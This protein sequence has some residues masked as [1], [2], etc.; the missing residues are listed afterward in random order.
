MVGPILGPLDHE[1]ALDSARTTI[2]T[3]T[4][5]QELSKKL[6]AAAQAAADYFE[7]EGS[8]ES[9]LLAVIKEHVE[10]QNKKASGEPV[11]RLDS[12]VVNFGEGAGVAKSARQ[13]A[14]E[15]RVGGVVINLSIEL[16]PGNK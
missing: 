4:D 2:R 6:T 8:L 15:R 9:R 12:V 5:Q 13:R 3:M 10:A 1:R 14:M 16:R 11:V 7:E